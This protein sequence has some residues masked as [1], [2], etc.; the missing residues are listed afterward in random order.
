MVASE[1]QGA[2]ETMRTTRLAGTASYRTLE[3]G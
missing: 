3:K 1:I 2:D